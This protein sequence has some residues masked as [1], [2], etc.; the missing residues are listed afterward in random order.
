[1]GRKVVIT[2]GLGCL[3]AAVAEAFARQGAQIALVEIA[4]ATGGAGPHLLLEDVDLADP[5][6]ARRA[7][8][9][10]RRA[11][12][13]IDVLVNVAGGFDMEPAEG[14]A[15][16]V[17]DKLYSANLK[18]CVNMCAAAIE[19]VAAGGAIVNVG[20]VAADDP[21]R[22]MGAYAASKSGVAR[23]TQSLAQTLGGRIRVNAVLPR[24]IDTPA[25]RAAMPDAD[26]S[27]WTSPAAIADVIAFLAS[28]QARA[29]NG[30]LLP[31][32]NAA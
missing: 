8:A 25:N 5:E 4:R 18:T 12:G 11:L 24:T 16:E 22:G 27:A 20:A 10:I 26:R 28:D 14:L 21:G 6:A 9:R 7:C 23:L 32:T 13:E 17:W 3:G 31:V 30:A 29:V 15:P 2:G 19:H 1:M